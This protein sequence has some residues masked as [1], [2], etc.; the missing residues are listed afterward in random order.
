M[1]IVNTCAVTNSFQAWRKANSAITPKM[2][3][4]AGT[5]ICQKMRKGPA[6]SIVAASSR[7]LGTPL[8][9]PE[10]IKMLA[11][12]PPVSISARPTIFLVSPSRLMRVYRGYSATEPTE[13]NILSRYAV[14]ISFLPTKSRRLIT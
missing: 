2:G 1:A 7:S 14:E 8:M 11:A 9:K 12:W 13:M 10:I 3:L 5:M 6:P 4:M